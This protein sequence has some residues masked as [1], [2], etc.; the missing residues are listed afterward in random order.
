MNKIYKIVWSKIKNTYVVVSEVAKS[1]S[2]SGQVRGRVTLVAAVLGV[3]MATALPSSG[4]YA[5]ELNAD[6]KAVYDAVLQELAKNGVHYVSVKG[7]SQ[8]N[9]S[10]YKND[11][12][13]GNGAVAIGEKALAYKGG[14]VSI[15]RNAHILGNG[16]NAS[17][18]GV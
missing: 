15:G 16:G 2:K 12:A 11:G 6:Q 18:E 8:N 5:A 3:L 10:N 9:D 7:E 4:V 1:H 14:T 13:K 17:G